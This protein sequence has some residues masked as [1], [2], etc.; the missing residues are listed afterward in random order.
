VKEDLTEINE[1]TTNIIE[2]E[3][4]RKTTTNSTN[5]NVNYALV[6]ST[7]PVSIPLENGFDREDYEEYPEELKK[8]INI[9]YKNQKPTN[10]AL[11]ILAN[12]TGENNIEQ[13][14]N[15]IKQEENLLLFS[16]INKLIQTVKKQNKTIQ[17]LEN[18]NMQEEVHAHS[19]LF[20]NLTEQKNMVD[21]G[22]KLTEH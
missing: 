13:L 10:F 14:T 16:E 18:R 9:I 20:K 8:L 6:P 5:N 22:S 1:T 3:L 21:F 12:E 19:E 4:S 2:N 15:E 11:E 7:I 17:E